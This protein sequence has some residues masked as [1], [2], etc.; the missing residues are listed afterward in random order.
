MLTN[1]IPRNEFESR[2]TRVQALCKKRGV[3]AIVVWGRG[4]G[5]MDTSDDLLYLANLVPVFPYMPDSPGDW[6]GL[7]HAAVIV[8]A[9][10]EPV[11]VTEAPIF[12][13]QFEHRRDVIPIKDIRPANAFAPD[14]VVD[15]LKSMGLAEDRIGLVAGHWM[16]AS[17]YRRLLEVGKG[18]DFIDMDQ[19]ICE[20]RAHKSPLEFELLREANA[21][22]SEAAE[23]MMKSA[24]TLG[25][26]EADAVS[27]ALAITSR[28]SASLIDAPTASGPNSHFF[29]Y[30]MAPQWTNRSLL[31]GDIFHF[32][33][34]GAA[35]EGYR[36]D[37][38][39]SVINGGKWSR[40]Q[41]EIYEGLMAAVHAGVDACRPGAPCNAIWAAVNG[42]LKAKDLCVADFG[43]HGHSYGLGW[44]APFIT[45]RT[46][47]KVEAGMAFAIEAMAGRED[48]GFFLFERNV[49]VHEDKNEIIDTCPVRI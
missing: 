29:A 10:G 45:P 40:E 30:G 24:A 31:P 33:C 34:Y 20:L 35:T 18:I 42:A 21:I 13:G 11:L 41:E 2:W 12:Y 49:L 1:R 47:T 26:T 6:S 48:V 46:Q 39:R 22:G 7:S 8:P 43:C 16:I 15:A 28:H 4:G 14:A 32:D 23:A 38:Q 9:K 17:V 3:G 37:F 44:E 36:W 25:T 19:A 27:A 5:P